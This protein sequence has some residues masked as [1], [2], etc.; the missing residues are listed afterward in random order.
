MGKH[1]RNYC[2]TA[3]GHA[4]LSWEDERITYIIYAAE[5]GASGYEHLQGY[6]ELASATSIKTVK[7]IFKRPDLHLEPRQGTQHQAIMYCKKDWDKTDIRLE[8]GVPKKQGKRTDLDR[9]VEDVLHGKKIDQVKE[10][11]PG[12]WARNH[13]AIDIAG[14][15]FIKKVAKEL[16]TKPINVTLILGKPGTGKSRYIAEETDLDNSYYLDRRTPLWFDGYEGEHTLIIDDYRGEIPFTEL[17]RILDRYFYQLNVKGGHSYK[18][19]ENVYISSNRTIYDWYP[20][21]PDI[22]ALERRIHKII[23]L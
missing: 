9:A 23:H 13:R 2:F 14:R 4:R 15:T 3:Q 17:L 22:A 6:M 11:T 1:H 19:W 7:K 16:H 18:C 10:D 8:H 12:L 20:N 21:E 5:V